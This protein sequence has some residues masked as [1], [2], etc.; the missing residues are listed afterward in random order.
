VNPE[1]EQAEPIRA[2]LL[3]E[4]LEPKLAQDNILNAEPKREK[5]RNDM[6]LPIFT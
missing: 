6:E 3:K 2:K 1:T 4:K 5:L